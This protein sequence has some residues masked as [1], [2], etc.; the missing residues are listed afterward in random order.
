MF[1]CP[2]WMSEIRINERSPFM[3]VNRYVITKRCDIV[4]LILPLRLADV[5]QYTNC[6]EH[7]YVRIENCHFNTFNVFEKL[8]YYLR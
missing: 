3:L 8:A 5:S 2:T 4:K 6:T 1:R 7:L